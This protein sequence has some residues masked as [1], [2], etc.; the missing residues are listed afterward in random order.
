MSEEAQILVG[1]ST[2]LQRKFHTVEDVANILNINVYAVRKLVRIGQLRATRLGGCRIRISE[3]D[4]EDFLKKAVSGEEDYL[5]IQ[6]VA[7]LLGVHYETIRRW[8]KAGYLKATKVANLVKI[9]LADWEEFKRVHMIDA[10]SSV[11]KS[12]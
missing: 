4:L 3:S 6:D 2:S 12:K 10:A 8:V 11:K 5:S 7:T 9:P 1:Q